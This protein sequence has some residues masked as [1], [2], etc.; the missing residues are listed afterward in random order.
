VLQPSSQLVRDLARFQG[1]SFVSCY[2]PFTRSGKDVRQ[3]AIHLKNCQRAIAAAGENGGADPRTT[4]AAARELNNAA[5]AVE[6][7][8]APRRASGLALF[9]S[10]GECVV[11]ESTAPFASFVTIGPR[12]YVVP[13]VP[14]TT[15]TPS[16]FVLSL[17]RHVVRLVEYPS[18][19]EV[20]LANGVPRSMSDVVGDER[21]DAT[22]QQHSVGNGSV[23]HG[24]G[25]GDDDLLPEVEVFCRHLAHALASNVDRS[26]AL[27]LL[28]GDIQVT[29]VF[30]RA[31]AAAGWTLL[32]EQI[33]GNHDRTTAAQL[34]AFA[35][36]LVSAWQRTTN[37]D[38]REL[39]GARSAEGRA[40]D[41]AGDIAA[42][43]EVGRVD[44]LLLDRTVA[45]DE[46]QLRATQEP[47]TIQ[48][49][50]PFNSEAVLTLRHGGSVHLLAPTDMPT[51][52]PQAAIYRF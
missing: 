32:E 18:A 44:T 17:S 19:R 20:E 34:A 1:D 37:P 51:G 50:G 35:E 21:R 12:F 49:E 40:S 43:A 36:P 22:L 11:L 8:R 52:A 9:A 45:L 29:A 13:L 26:D 24:H 33:H 46:P 25:E 2:V 48:P 42:A 7:P 16:V 31:A 23:F 38:L 6:D 47:H 5:R 3:N 39:Y 4:A 14:C 30:R 27:L 15:G 41:V 10:P 28:A